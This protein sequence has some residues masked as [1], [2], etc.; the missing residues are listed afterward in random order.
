MESPRVTAASKQRRGAASRE[1]GDRNRK[2]CKLLREG[3][4][5]REVGLRLGVSAATILRVKKSFDGEI[6]W[7]DLVRGMDGKLQPGRKRSRPAA[8]ANVGD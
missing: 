7:P 5:A 4:S 1:R 2:I 6:D 3:L 8:T